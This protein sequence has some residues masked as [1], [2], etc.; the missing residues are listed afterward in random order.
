MQEG[1]EKWHQCSCHHSWQVV[2]C[3]LL[4]DTHTQ[5]Q[6]S[7]MDTPTSV[8]RA[9]TSRTSMSTT[10]T[11][12]FSCISSMW[13]R[14]SSRMSSP[15]STSSVLRVDFDTRGAHRGVHDHGAVPSNHYRVRRDSSQRVVGVAFSC[16]HN[17]SSCTWCGVSSVSGS[18]SHSGPSS[19]TFS[20]H[21]HYIGSPLPD[22]EHLV[23]A[24]MSSGTCSPGL[25]WSL[26]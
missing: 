3:A 11:I 20:V 15:S 10:R 22:D 26:M 5:P 14:T 24:G 17:V 4:R 23:D 13:N 12:V 16:H 7:C 2:S 9:S 6:R 1:R 8:Q 21:R 19:Q 18:P 25:R